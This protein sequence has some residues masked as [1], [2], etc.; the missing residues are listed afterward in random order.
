M[1]RRNLFTRIA[2]LGVAGAAAA[3]I[4]GCKADGTLNLSTTDLDK[5]AQALAYLVTTV[6][7]SQVFTKAT[8]AE[9]A[10]INAVV[11]QITDTTAEI[12]SGSNG[13]ISIDVSANWAKSLVGEVTLFVNLAT[14]I[15]KKYNPTIASYLTL[16]SQL[17]PFVQAIVDMATAGT[18]TSKAAARAR[19]SGSLFGNPANIRAAIYRG[20]SA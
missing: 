1:E 10:Q 2:K 7:N 17:L 15:V 19:V 8:D 13:T 6:E 12:A 3:L 14:P 11:K 16:A 18:D 5:D 9:R 4:A 20:P